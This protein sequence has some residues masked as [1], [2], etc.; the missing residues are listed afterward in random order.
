VAQEVLR[1][2][3]R[4]VALEVARGAHHEEAERVREPHLHHVALDVLDQAHP[5]VVALG[6][7]VH[8]PILERNLDL[9]PW[10]TRTKGGQHRLDHEGHRQPRYRQPEPADGFSRLSGDFGESSERRAE[11]RPGGLE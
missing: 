5:R 6:H 1:T 4:P 3:G 10:V 11:R 2:L 9:D 8:A 7:D